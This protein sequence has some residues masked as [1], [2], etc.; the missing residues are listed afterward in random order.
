MRA[1]GELLPAADPDSLA[2][3]ILAAM[4]GGMLLTQ[5]LRDTAPLRASLAAVLTYL[6]TYAAD[7]GAAAGALRLPRVGGRSPGRADRTGGSLRYRCAD[8]A[9]RLLG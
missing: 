2:A 6:G 3:A 4:Q 8:R 1:R 7:P 5:T 9:D